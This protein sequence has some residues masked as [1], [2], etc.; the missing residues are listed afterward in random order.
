LAATIIPLVIQ[1]VVQQLGGTG[2]IKGVTSVLS[3]LG[4]NLN[5]EN[6]LVKQIQEK[7]K[8][9]DPQKATEYTQQAVDLI[10]QEATANPNGIESLFSNVL[11]SGSGNIEGELKKG[12]GDRLKGLFGSKK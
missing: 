8:I 10:K 7:T 9:E 6:P 1:Y 3:G 11:S 4:T 5:A 12:L 2:R